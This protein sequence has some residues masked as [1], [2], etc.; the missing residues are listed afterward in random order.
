MNDDKYNYINIEESVKQFKKDILEPVENN[1][2]STNMIESKTD[3][4]IDSVADTPPSQQTVSNNV[5]LNSSGTNP[6]ASVDDSFQKVMEAIRKMNALNNYN[7]HIN[8]MHKY[9]SIPNHPEFFRIYPDSNGN[10]LIF[11]LTQPLQP[12]ASIVLKDNKYIVYQNGIRMGVLQGKPE[13]TIWY[14][15]L[16]SMNIQSVNTPSDPKL[17]NKITFNNV[18]ADKANEI[19]DTILKSN[20]Q[21][22]VEVNFADQANTTA[23]KNP[24]K[25][26]D[27]EPEIIDITP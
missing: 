10:P 13:D 3:I 24:N 5:V 22:S 7:N 12:I 17:T 15:I 18:P 25:K 2:P 14:L 16:D 19:I 4:S 9:V 23:G 1:N 11:T 6:Q 20:I 8:C 21:N 27:E 26:D